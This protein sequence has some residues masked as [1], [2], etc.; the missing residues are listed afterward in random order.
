MEAKTVLRPSFDARQRGSHLRMTAV[1]VERT[2]ANVIAR[3]SC[4]EAIQS[5][6]VDRGLAAFEWRHC[7]KRPD[8]QIT[9]SPVKPSRDHNILIYRN[10]KSVYIPGHLIPP[11][12]AFRERHEMRDG[13]WWAVAARETGD[14]KADGQVVWS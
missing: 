14:A 11:G 6:F 13:L 12:G 5:F 4:D 1:H 9:R 10:S 2:R 7:G 8:G 3:C